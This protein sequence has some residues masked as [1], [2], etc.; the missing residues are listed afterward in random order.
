MIQTT[1]IQFFLRTSFNNRKCMHSSSQFIHQITNGAQYRGVIQFNQVT[2]S[3]ESKD[4][5]L[6]RNMLHIAKNSI[7]LENG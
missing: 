1:Y 2:L 7:S 3:Y 5:V 4:I 6:P